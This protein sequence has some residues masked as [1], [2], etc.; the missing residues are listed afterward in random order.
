[1]LVVILGSSGGR[2]AGVSIDDYDLTFPVLR[3]ALFMAVAIAALPYLARGVQRIIE[4]F[5]ALTAPA[6]AVGG[7]GLPL[8]VA[9]S[10]AIGWGAGLAVRLVFGSPL[11][12]A[13]ADDVR[14]LLRELGIEAQNVRSLSRQVWG[15][16]KYRATEAGPEGRPLSVH[17]YG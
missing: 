1:I 7:H 13:S 14:R 9:G 15:V 12:L 2:P 5:I 16:A 11:G 8:N 6:T 17:L 4:I 10:L 3:I